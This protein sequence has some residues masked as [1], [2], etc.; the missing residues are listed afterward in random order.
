MSLVVV[1]IWTLTRT[2]VS[3]REGQWY[4]CAQM[5]TSKN[6]Y[7]IQK[8]WALSLSVG[9]LACFS[10]WGHIHE[11]S[12][13]HVG[14]SLRRYRDGSLH[15]PWK[16]RF[17]CCYILHYF[18]SQIFSHVALY[19][20]ICAIKWDVNR[21]YKCFI[22]SMRVMWKQVPKEMATVLKSFKIFLFFFVSTIP[23]LSSYEIICR[24]TGN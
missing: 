4:I 9:N 1:L 15:M 21:Y 22:T 3:L 12:G 7:G 18:R 17:E 14:L 10:R 8:K 6:L 16:F 23:F 19:A 24:M 20:F 11:R 5:W 13:S 2:A